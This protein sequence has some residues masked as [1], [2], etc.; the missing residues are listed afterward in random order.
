MTLKITDP[1]S[2]LFNLVS[3][4]GKSDL[5]GIYLTGVNVL[6]DAYID[7]EYPVSREQVEREVEVT[8][9]AA[10]GA[11]WNHLLVDMRRNRNDEIAFPIS[12]LRGREP[13]TVYF[14]I[15]GNDISSMVFIPA[16]VVDE[17]ATEVVFYQRLLTE[18]ARFTGKTATTIRFTLGAVSIEWD[19]AVGRGYAQEVDIGL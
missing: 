2:F 19:E 16:L 9:S 10:D 4:K 6:A 13:V 3:K 1:N 14:L 18:V 15:E 5:Y 8:L 7:Y 17:F 11:D 12:F